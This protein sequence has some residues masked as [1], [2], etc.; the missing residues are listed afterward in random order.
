MIAKGRL[1]DWGTGGLGARRKKWYAYFRR[2]VL[3]AGI[4]SGLFGVGGGIVMVP[5]QVLMLKMPIKEAVQT[6]YGAIVLVSLWA[7]TRYLI[8]DAT[9]VLL[10]PGTILGVGSFIGANFGAR[11]LPKLSDKLVRFLFTGL[12][13]LLA[14]YMSFKA[15][16][17]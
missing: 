4:L 11:L 14:S 8:A 9:N 7:V 17:A 5:L 13:V 1:G 16:S 15:L 10:V 12:L 6:S 2:L 3:V